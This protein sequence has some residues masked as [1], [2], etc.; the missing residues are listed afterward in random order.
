[1]KTQ[2]YICLFIFFYL[3]IFSCKPLENTFKSFVDDDEIATITTD[4]ETELEAAISIL[5]KKGGTI[6]IDTAVINI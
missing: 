1:M 5:N 6:Y 2:I 4:D 3:N